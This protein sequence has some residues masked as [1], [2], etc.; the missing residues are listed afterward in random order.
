MSTSIEHVLNF[1]DAAADAAVAKA[2][3]T[4]DA[5]LDN[6]V[7]SIT[8]ASVSFLPI[9]ICFA[10]A[11]KTLTHLLFRHVRF[12]QSL[13]SLH[14]AIKHSLFIPSFVRFCQSCLSLSLPHNYVFLRSFSFFLNFKAGADDT[15]AAAEAAADAEGLT[16]LAQM[17]RKRYATLRRFD[18]GGR[19]DHY[20]RRAHITTNRVRGV[21]LLTHTHA[22]TCTHHLHTHI[23]TGDYARS[24]ARYLTQSQRQAVVAQL[25]D[26]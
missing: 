10:F 3:S 11:I 21:S 5:A 9:I 20:C 25:R 14:I 16:R 4:A 19:S 7:G 1:V 24:V 17:T 15:A 2:E 12:F 23:H 22:H 26:M 13:M 6:F 8:F 18:D